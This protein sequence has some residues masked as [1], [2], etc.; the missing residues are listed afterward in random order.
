MNNIEPRPA[1]NLIIGEALEAGAFGELDREEETLLRLRAGGDDPPRTIEEV[2]IKTGQPREWVRL[3]EQI[4]I[5]RLE[6]SPWWP[7]L[8]AALSSPPQQA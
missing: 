4:L 1:Y 2:A 7:R 3:L 6:A 5:E 8:S